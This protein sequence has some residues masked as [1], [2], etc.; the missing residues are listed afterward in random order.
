MAKSVIV[1]LLDRPQEK[2]NDELIRKYGADAVFRYSSTIHFIET[3]DLPTEVRTSVMG[4]GKGT[5]AIFR[6]D[7]TYSGYTRRDL[8]QWIQ[9]TVL[10]R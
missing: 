4:D 5:G 9:G 3:G 7:E 1:V 10:K 6:V 8:W 2:I